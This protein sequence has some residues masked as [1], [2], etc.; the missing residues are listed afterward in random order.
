MPHS[1]LVW[2]EL[3]LAGYAF[4]TIILLWPTLG[5]AVVPW[6]SIYIAGFS[7]VAGLSFIQTWQIGRLKKKVAAREKVGNPF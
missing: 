7:Y 2:G 4:S 1:P 5:L 3:I 6:M